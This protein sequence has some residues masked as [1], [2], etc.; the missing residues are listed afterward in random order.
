[1]EFNQYEYESIWYLGWSW[2]VQEWGLPQN[3]FVQEWGLPQNA[4]FIRE[5]DGQQWDS[6]LTTMFSDIPILPSSSPW[7]NVILVYTCHI[8][9]Q[10]RSKSRLAN[11]K[12]TVPGRCQGTRRR[13]PNLVIS[14]SNDLA[15][16]PP[17]LR[18]TI[19]NNSWSMRIFY[20]LCI[21]YFCIFVMFI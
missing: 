2:F 12:K 14:G 17:G 18:N 19:Q 7:R 6:A 20:I 10:K 11:T 21:P 13:F 16:Q 4:A 15:S 9:L 1:M 5:N 3:A 8:L